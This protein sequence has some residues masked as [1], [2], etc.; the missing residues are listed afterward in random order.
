MPWSGTGPPRRPR[1]LGDFQ[2]SCESL[3]QIMN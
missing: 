1:S 3:M 2:S